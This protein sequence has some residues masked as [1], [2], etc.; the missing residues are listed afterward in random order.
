MRYNI[1]VK[2]TQPKGRKVKGDFML[3]K[4]VCEYVCDYNLR[5]MCVKACSKAQAKSIVRQ[6]LR[7]HGYKVMLKDI[8][9]MYIDNG[10]KA[11]ND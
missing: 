7:E 6:I 5:T 8:N 11:V 4:Y 2:K 3:N 10:R 1:I 9:P